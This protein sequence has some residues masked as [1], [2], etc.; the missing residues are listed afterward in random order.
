MKP[1]VSIEGPRSSVSREN[2]IDSLSSFTEGYIIGR[3]EFIELV[4]VSRRII[5]SDRV[6]PTGGDVFECNT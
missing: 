6:N 5:A 4:N 2:C 1:A 3:K